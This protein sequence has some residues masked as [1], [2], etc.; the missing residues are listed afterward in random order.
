MGF[1]FSLYGAGVALRAK[2]TAA[3]N[4][5]DFPVPWINTRKLFSYPL[6]HESK[7]ESQKSKVKSQKSKVESQKSKVKS[8]MSKV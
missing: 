6:C 2:K 7:V 5:E 8:R 1:S 4:L 3:A